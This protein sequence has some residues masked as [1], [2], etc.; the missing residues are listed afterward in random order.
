SRDP[1]ELVDG[2]RLPRKLPVVL[3]RDE[4]LALLAAPDVDSTPLG[5]RDA[6]MLHTM[7]AAG[8]RVS[9]LVRLDLA[10]VNLESG[11]VQAFGKG[12]KRRIV[13]LGVPAQKRII[14]W[15]DEV[16]GRWAP[17][18]SRSLFVTESGGAMT[19]QNFFAR[20]R[21]WARVAGIGRA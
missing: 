7:Y 16:R 13:P 2:P 8:L 15:R 17:S 19:R 21:H 20:V 9:E 6:A 3:A 4:V 14:R 10:D 1:T 12:Q 5:I 11:F 18:S